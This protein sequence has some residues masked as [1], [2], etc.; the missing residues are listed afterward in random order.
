MTR[1]PAG[2]PTRR[3]ALTGLAASAALGAAGC[4][5]ATEVTASEASAAGS[6]TTPTAVSAAPLTPTPTPSPT[7]PPSVATTPGPDLT[8]A[9]TGRAEVALTFHGAGDS[10]I[11]DAVLGILAEHTAFM[12]VFAIGQWV[13]ANPDLIRAI[14]AAGHEVGNHT[15]SHPDL[16]TMEEAAV[17]DEIRRGREALAAVLGE[18]GWWFRPSA[19]Q[20]STET[21]RA[22]ARAEGYAVCVSYG[23]DPEDFRDPGADLVRS[24]TQAAIQPGAIVSL[25][26]GHPGTVEALPG[27]LEDLAAVSLAPVTLTALVRS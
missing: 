22:A 7:G 8:H 9:T 17:R 24:R 2:F 21:I 23:V 4:S 3:L 26:L 1:P 18:P 15:W 5:S 20:T 25:H 10:A 13:Q 16:P 19:T 6:S 14:A 11:A 12:T 27:I